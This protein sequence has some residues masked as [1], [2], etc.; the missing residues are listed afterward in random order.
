[1]ASAFSQSTF[2]SADH[3]ELSPPPPKRG[4]SREGQPRTT[5]F[6]PLG[7]LP[8]PCAGESNPELEQGSL[9]GPGLLAAL[10]AAVWQLEVARAA[11]AATEH[12]LGDGSGPRSEKASLGFMLGGG[13]VGLS[14]LSGAGGC[15][16]TCLS[17]LWFRDGEGR[18]TT[19]DA[20]EFTPA[21]APRL[22]RTGCMSRGVYTLSQ[23]LW[24]PSGRQLWGSL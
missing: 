5:L 2:L 6:L 17:F 16:S 1:M 7:Y 11:G 18:A 8:G 19:M 14:V 12:S 15:K 10:Q 24:G 13:G 20:A 23:D 22:P 4:P 9:P 3:M 21:L